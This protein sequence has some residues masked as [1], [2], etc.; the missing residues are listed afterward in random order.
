MLQGEMLWGPV[1]FGPPYSCKE[2]L[3]QAPRK[4]DKFTGSQDELWIVP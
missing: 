3:T 2:P 4:P 1:V